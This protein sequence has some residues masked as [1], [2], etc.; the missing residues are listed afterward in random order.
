MKWPL[1]IVAALYAGGLI[2]GNYFQ[3]P[4]PCLFA[5]ALSFAA[6]ALLLSRFRSF[7]LWPLIVLTGWTNIVW[8]TAV[9]SPNDLRALLGNQPELASIRGTLVAMPTERVYLNDQ[10]LITIRTMARVDVTAIQRGDTNWQVAVGRIAV[11]NSGELPEDFFAG[12]EVQIDGVLA[13]PPGPL[14][15]GLFDFRN[16][17]RRQEIYFEVKT[18]PADWQLVNTNKIA[19]PLSDRFMK[20]AKVALALGVT[21][22]SRG[23]DLSRSGSGERNPTEGGGPRG[24]SELE[25]AS[26]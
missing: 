12:R 25:R 15:D 7:L 6:A 9:V 24:P 20:W 8:H 21:T 17:L 19:L 26:H 1:G 11:V 18:H 23:A 10:G 22:N 4:L 16:Y 2:L 3:P 14:A 5:V 13:P